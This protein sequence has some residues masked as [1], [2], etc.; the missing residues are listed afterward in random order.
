MP[1]SKAKKQTIRQSL[2]ILG[3]QDASIFDSCVAERGD[4]FKVVK[5]TYFQQVLKAHP[6]KGG[7]A[8]V[9]RDIQTSFELLRDLHYGKRT[10]SWLFSECVGGASAKDDPT[11]VSY[12]MSE[13]DAEFDNME[14][15]SYE[16]YAHA[17]DE[18]VPLYRVE[19]GKQHDDDPPRSL[20][21]LS[22]CIWIDSHVRSLFFRSFI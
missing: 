12:N 18:E 15:P 21:R 19:L 3:I 16:Y 17:A 10:G 22:P 5:K 6:D 8:A 20:V 9:F 7:D 4:E 2:E 11:D 1:P 13:Y 14:T